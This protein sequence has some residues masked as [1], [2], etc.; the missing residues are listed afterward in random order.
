MSDIALEEISVDLM[1]PITPQLLGGA[2]YVLVVVDLSSHFSW[3]RML[4][5]KSEGKDELKKIIKQSENSI[6]KQVKKIVCDG[7]K[8]FVNKFVKEFREERGIQLTITTPYTPQHNGVVERINRTLMD[9]VRTLM[10][11]SGMEK[12][13]WAE[14]LN[15]EKFLR[16]RISDGDKSPFEKLFNKK[17]NL[18][19]I[20]RFGCRAYVTNNSYKRKLD[21]R[22]LKGVLVGYEPDFGVYHILLEDTGKIIR[23][24]DVRFNEDE[25]PLKTK[26][27]ISPEEDQEITENI[28]PVLRSNEEELREPI[29]IRIRIPRIQ[30]QQELELTNTEN[31]N[32]ETDGAENTRPERNRGKPRPQWEWSMR[33]QA[34]NNIG[35]EIV[36]ENI[37]NEPRRHRTQAYNIEAGKEKNE[38]FEK[39][40]NITSIAMSVENIERINPNTLKEASS[41]HDWPK[42]KEAYFS[43]LDSILEQNVFEIFI[44]KDLPKQKSLINTRWVFTKK[45]DENGQLQRYK[46]RCVARGFKQKEG[47]DYQETFSPTG[48]LST[49]R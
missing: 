25:L 7:G 32:I 18:R 31:Q 30:E 45:F 29:R 2:K 49:L 3:V 12:E 9:K 11:E 38:A 42:L 8:E 46:A 13:L 39:Y 19:R 41:M 16:V 27:K 33:S 20:R 28:E 15:T 44:K 1:G 34:P 37:S 23:S 24:R 17:P 14:S 26:R 21:E 35:S 43:E 5:S 10:F 48:R 22:A 47:I 40:D 36:E 4:K 6:E